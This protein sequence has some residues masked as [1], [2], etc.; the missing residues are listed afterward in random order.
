MPPLI[1]QLS[2]EK[3]INLEIYS[4]RKPGRMVGL[5]FYFGNKTSRTKAE[6]YLSKSLVF[7]SNYLA[8]IKNNTIF[9]T[10]KLVA[11]FLLS[12]VG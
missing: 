11:T 8:K 3:R 6:K 1:A 5:I 9:A 12:S 10:A 2:L 7:F 4:A